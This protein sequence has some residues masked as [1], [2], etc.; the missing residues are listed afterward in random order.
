M[1]SLGTIRVREMAWY[2]LSIASHFEV[3][4][5]FLF[6]VFFNNVAELKLSHFITTFLQLLDFLHLAEEASLSAPK[7]QLSFSA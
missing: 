2:I 7:I 1:S 5:V 6:L 4:Q 3:V